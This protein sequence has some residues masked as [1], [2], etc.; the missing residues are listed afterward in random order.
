MWANLRRL[1]SPAGLTTIEILIDMVSRIIDPFNLVPHDK[2]HLITFIL[3]YQLSA[4]AINYWINF[5]LFI[6]MNVYNFQQDIKQLQSWINQ[7]KIYVMN[8]K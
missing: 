3:H 2:S 4:I 8:T 7:L 6:F 1:A 5:I